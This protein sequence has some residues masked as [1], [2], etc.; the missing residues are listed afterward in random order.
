MIYKMIYEEDKRIAMNAY[1][2]STKKFGNNILILSSDKS[3]DFCV[4]KGVK[5]NIMKLNYQRSPRHI[6][7]IKFLCAYVAHEFYICGN[8]TVFISRTQREN[9]TIYGRCCIVDDIVMTK[10]LLFNF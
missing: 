6:Y 5:L 10:F 4:G 9:Y 3:I 8:N 2:F 7:R 1:K